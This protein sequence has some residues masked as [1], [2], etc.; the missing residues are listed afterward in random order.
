MNTRI[1]LCGLLGFSFH[2]AALAQEFL[3]AAKALERVAAETAAGKAGEVKKNPAALWLARAEEF[4]KAAPALEAKDAA[5]Q[6]LALADEWR[7]LPTDQPDLQPSIPGLGPPGERTIIAL[8]KSLP[9]P[10]AW[11]ALDAAASARPRDG[12]DAPFNLALKLLAGG[13]RGEFQKVDATAKEFTAA[14]RK[15]RRGQFSSYALTNITTWI[16]AHGGELW[17]ESKPGQGTTFAF[18]LGT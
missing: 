11:D 3:G 17:C 8:M 10:A 5:T 18:T 12:N 16:E 1:I 6:W 7:A 13:L 14:A 15:A 9:P 2:H 4:A